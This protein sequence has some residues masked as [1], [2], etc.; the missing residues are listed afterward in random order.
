MDLM[1]LEPI[2]SSQ[3]FLKTAP[4]VSPVLCQ[5]PVM[6]GY[7]RLRSL[8]G[9]P[10]IGFLLDVLSQLSYRPKVGTGGIEPPTDRV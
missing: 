10:T 7:A 1:G 9:T 6:S 2:A 8:N 3:V 5:R 4:M